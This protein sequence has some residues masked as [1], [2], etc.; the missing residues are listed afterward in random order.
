MLQVMI[1]SRLFLIA[2][3]VALLSSCDRSS[4]DILKDSSLSSSVET[5]SAWAVPGKGDFEV[6]QQMAELFIKSDKDNPAIIDVTPY[7]VDGVTCFYIFNFEKGFKVISADTRIQPFLAES[8]EGELY[9]EKNDNPGIK[10]WLEDTADR[11]KMLKTYNPETGEDYSELWSPYRIPESLRDIVGKRQ[12]NTR[13][14]EVDS[15]WVLVY[16][17]TVEDIYNYSDIGPLLSTK[18]G[19]RSPWYKKMPK[20][21]STSCLT[22]CAAVATSQALYYFNRKTGYP[23][24]FWHSISIQSTSTCL[25]HGGLLVSLNKTSHTNYSSRWSQMPLDKNGSNTDYVSYLMLDVGDRLSMHYGTSVSFVCLASDLS[26]P[27]LSSC[28]ISSSFGSYS[29]SIVENSI[30]QRQPVIVTSWTGT[31]SGVGHTWVID[32]CWDFY[33][34][35]TSTLA[36]YCIHPDELMYYQNNSGVLSYDEMMSLYPEASGG[37]YV[38]SSSIIYDNQQSLHMNWGW[39]GEGDAWYNMLDSNDWIYTDPLGNSINFLYN[40]VIHYN[41][42]TSQLN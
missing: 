36:Y 40:R 10:V 21:G 28:G 12:E 34:K 37:V 41:I 18:W 8:D 5:R 6:T 7:A 35:Y 16:D 26:I 38:L 27:N 25:T 22:G 32:G 19:Q 30:L 3:L 14:Y 20:V 1:N 15:I 11:I 31:L 33:K 23:N 9:P 2:V 4:S 39:D 17:T 13:D 29:F 42:S 24:D